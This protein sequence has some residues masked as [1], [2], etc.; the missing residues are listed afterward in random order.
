MI[1]A[2][3]AY[4]PIPGHPR[5]EAAYRELGQH[6]LEAEI[7]LMTLEGKL[8]Q[9]WLYQYL[10]W[11]KRDFTH[12]VADNPAKNS[13]PYHVVQAQKS[14]W[15]VDA[16]FSNPNVDV[17]CWIDYGIFSIPG[18]TGA[19]IRDFLMRAANEQTIA[20]PGCWGSDY[21][22]DD[23]QPCWRFCGGVLVVPRQYVIRS[24]SR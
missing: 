19:I 15:L 7:P 23:S 5:P 10:H 20:I 8:D 22:Y 9:C 4:V 21:K 6:L 18:V 12:S 2:V 14:E 16:A 17:L 3:T 1:T 11:R 13:I 24:T